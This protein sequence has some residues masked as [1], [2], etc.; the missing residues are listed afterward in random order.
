MQKLLTENDALPTPSYPDPT[1]DSIA[2]S[3]KEQ[4][5]L[6]MFDLQDTSKATKRGSE[7]LIEHMENVLP[8]LNE[9]LAN[10]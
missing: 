6:M 9:R 3:R 2:M 8:V 10:L 4:I 1:S 5:L 7:A